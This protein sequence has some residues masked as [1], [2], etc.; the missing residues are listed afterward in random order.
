M[1]FRSE[2][3]KKIVLSFDNSKIVTSEEDSAGKNKQLFAK[4][5]LTYKKADA[6][7][8]SEAKLTDGEGSGK[9]FDENADPAAVDL[10]AGARDYLRRAGMS[11][12]QIDAFLARI[13]EP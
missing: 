8:I 3:S 2:A 9:W 12:E 11:D 1:L 13:V 6:S 10:S 7:G 5:V 4:I